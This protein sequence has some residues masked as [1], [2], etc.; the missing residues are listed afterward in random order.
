[1]NYM[2]PLPFDISGAVFAGHSQAQTYQV[3]VKYMI[4]KIPTISDPSLLVLSRPSSSYDPLALELYARATQSLPVAVTVD[5]NPL[6]EWFE[7][8]MDVLS[9]VAP[10]VGAGLTPLIPMAGGIGTGLGQL[11]KGAA[12]RNRKE[13]TGNGKSPVKA[14]VTVKPQSQNKRALSR[15]NAVTITTA[16]SKKGGSLTR[17]EKKRRKQADAQIAKFLKSPAYKPGYDDLAFS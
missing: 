3:T 5:M 6:G 2:H 4:E 11:A 10:L 15:A 1:M 9:Q 12:D 8:L 13:R 16:G 7:G 17:K 14:G